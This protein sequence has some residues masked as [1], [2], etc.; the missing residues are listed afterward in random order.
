MNTA[1]PDGAG[2]A[3]SYEHCRQMA[4][5]SSFYP[6][7]FL[8]NSERRLALW[9]IYAFNRHCDDL[10]DSGHASQTA[11]QAWATDLR[12]VLDGG[13]GA[14]PLWPAFV[15]AVRRHR[16]PDRCF[17]EMI[18]GVSSDLVETRKETYEDLYR[19]C[20][21]VASVVGIS[22]SAIFGAR[23]EEAERLA[24]KC[25]VAVQ[26]TNV[27]RDVAEDHALGRVYLPQED[28]RRFGV[29]RIGD[30]DPMRGLLR[31][32]A[33]RAWALYEEGRPLVAMVEPETRACLRAILGVYERLLGRI[34]ARNFDVFSGRVRLTGIEKA[35]VLAR[36]LFG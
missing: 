26:L 8:V 4:S 6:A 11:L 13:N 2:L 3:A 12:C 19:Y 7:F 22:V 24:E 5:G 20:Y 28:L 14:H 17:F 1:S 30:S 23:G 15:D 21:R 18:E 9:A 16:I 31:F 34:E 27:L 29:D 25:G 36:A 10:S 33:E 35:G 32:E